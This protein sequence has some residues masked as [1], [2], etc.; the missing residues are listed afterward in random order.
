MLAFSWI[1]LLKAFFLFLKVIIKL[2]CNYIWCNCMSNSC[3]WSYKADI[4]AFQSAGTKRHLC[5]GGGGGMTAHKSHSDAACQEL[6]GKWWLRRQL[7]HDREKISGRA[8]DTFQHVWMHPSS[9]WNN[10]IYWSRSAFKKKLNFVK[11]VYSMFEVHL[12]KN[13]F[14][15]SDCLH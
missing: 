3:W 8:L 4:E 11:N 6:T 14:F 5:G 1:Q 15:H 9:C 10:I 7:R 2:W 13:T 12:K